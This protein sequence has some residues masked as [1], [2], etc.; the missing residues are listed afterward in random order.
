MSINNKLAILLL[1]IGLFSSLEF[2]QNYVSGLNGKE[3]SDLLENLKGEKKS[4]SSEILLAVV[5]YYP[6]PP[7]SGGDDDVFKGKTDVKKI[8]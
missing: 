8:V 5:M 1:S 2:A 4:D 6:A 7:D 3:K